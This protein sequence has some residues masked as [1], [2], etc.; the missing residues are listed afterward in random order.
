[1]TQSELDR[2]ME[3]LIPENESA[4][5]PHNDSGEH[6]VVVNLESMNSRIGFRVPN[7]ESI[8]HHSVVSAGREVLGL[9]HEYDHNI[10]SARVFKLVP[11][12]LNEV[13]EAI[14]KA[15]DDGCIELEDE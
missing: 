6:Y 7:E 4:K 2:Q 3:W 5:N 13:A 1:M 15:V 12:P 9:I 10:E 11:V 14:R 8:T